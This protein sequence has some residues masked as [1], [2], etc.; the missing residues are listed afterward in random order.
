MCAWARCR[1]V[2]TRLGEVC[3]CEWEVGGGWD[4]GCS[5][6]LGRAMIVGVCV[7]GG[8]VGLWDAV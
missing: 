6:T 4:Y 5:C 8:G 2:C 7:W 1:C 3:A